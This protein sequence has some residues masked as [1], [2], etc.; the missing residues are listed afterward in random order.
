M[1]KKGFSVATI[2]IVLASMF[3]AIPTAVAQV[4]RPANYMLVEY[5]WLKEDGAGP[6]TWKQYNNTGWNRLNLS[7]R[8]SK[9]DFAYVARSAATA[10]SF[11]VTFIVYHNQSA[12]NGFNKTGHLFP[13]S[14]PVYTITMPATTTQTA[15]LYTYHLFITVYD[16]AGV[17]GIYQL[18]INETGP[19]SG[20][21]W[22]SPAGNPNVQWMFFFVP[23]VSPAITVTDQLGR[24]QPFYLDGPSPSTKFNATMVI[25][26]PGNNTGATTATVKWFNPA[27]VQIGSTKTVPIYYVGAGKWAA[28]NVINANTSA[29]PFNASYPYSVQ[30]TM[31]Y[32]IQAGTF[33]V[34][35]TQ[36]VQ[37]SIDVTPVK[38]QWFD[39]SSFQ[40]TF[41]A[42]INTGMSY[43][44]Y[45]SVWNIS[46][47][48]WDKVHYFSG[49]VPVWRRGGVLANLSW[50]ITGYPVIPGS[51][52]TYTYTKMIPARWIDN[53]TDRLSE[54]FGDYEIRSVPMA[55][56]PAVTAKK[57]FYVDD[58]IEG[59]TSRVKAS[60]TKV[61]I[62][63]QKPA[64]IWA[65]VEFD[66]TYLRSRVN[67]NAA[68]TNKKTN[69]TWYYP[70][71]PTLL[72]P[73]GNYQTTM[74]QD[75]G[76]PSSQYWAFS[77]AKINATRPIG[78]YYI[79]VNA[80][81]NNNYVVRELITYSVV[82]RA[83]Y[84][85]IWPKWP[86]YQPCMKKTIIGKTYYLDEYDNEVPVDWGFY[87]YQLVDPNGV[88]YSEPT[89]SL[90]GYVQAFGTLWFDEWAPFPWTYTKKIAPSTQALGA[91][92][93]DLPSDAEPGT[94]TVYAM[95]LNTSWKSTGVQT[96]E[97]YSYQG[98]ATCTFVVS[99]EDV[100]FMIDDILAAIDE[101]SSVTWDKLAEV[102]TKLDSIS[103]QITSLKDTEIKS[104][105][106]KVDAVMSKLTSMDTSITAKLS[107]I[108]EYSREIRALTS[109]IDRWRTDLAT[110][111][112]D[113]FAKVIAEVKAV[114]NNINSKWTELGGLWDVTFWRTSRDPRSLAWRIENAKGEVL[115]QLT[116]T[117]NTMIA[118]MDTVNAG[119]AERLTNILNSIA[120]EAGGL[121]ASVRATITQNINYAISSIR[122]KVDQSTA[123]TGTKI[124]DAANGL[125]A[126]FAGVISEIGYVSDKV[127]KVY[128]KVG[129]VE[130]NIKDKVASV[131]SSVGTKLLVAIILIV[132]VLIL[133]LLPIVA[134][135]FRMKE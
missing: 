18:R 36:W 20:S 90:G 3:A 48:F 28:Q 11:N 58:P 75:A 104:I 70:T 62:F 5:A 59:Y 102:M 43:N 128:E 77:D 118:K 60:T 12:A 111:L 15:G 54:F 96:I 63:E 37:V 31:G 21:S 56:F 130:S 94:W 8:F 79:I 123:T 78:T 9:V 126:R 45:Q 125:H 114:N 124:A 17:P 49:G 69:I 14:T 100:H 107:S 44:P 116:N 25:A 30:I 47:Q 115:T 101:T 64:T 108:E 86:V 85:E 88:V 71:P 127:D 109:R 119:L 19:G 129:G 51:S 29:F 87:I 46:L 103:S 27:G 35:S 113:N 23:T 95:A 34:L 26:P 121:D 1:Y 82:Y 55:Q 76:W 61:G 73:P 22:T 6:E 39:P 16:P 110:M 99:G 65:N 72:K 89:E 13:G 83:L 32:F 74:T 40:V 131:D 67:S 132:I 84:L 98:P 57:A 133:C 105:I 7:F 122:E 33:Y 106:T 10:D 91:I 42:Q 24:P 50:N 92:V 80:T 66:P 135:G 4:P 41:T 52:Y 112:T 117:L 2:G 134:P 93:D 68:Y 97:P 120:S 81:T 53:S 38:G